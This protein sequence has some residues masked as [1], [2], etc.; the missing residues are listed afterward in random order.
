MA[1]GEGNH[2][3]GAGAVLLERRG[4][5][6]TIVLNRPDVRNAL[7]ADLEAGLID[8]L[9]HAGEPDVRAVVLSARGPVFCSGA[10]TKEL[11]GNDERHA[12]AL[13]VRAREL[14]ETVLMPLMRLEKPVIAAINGPAVGAGIGLALAADFRVCAESAAFTFAF[15]RVALAPDLGT[16]WTLPRIVGHRAARDLLMFGRT[17]AAQDALD[18][19]L[20]DRVVADADLAEASRELAQDLA[21]GPTLAL[22]LTKMLLRRAHDLDLE[23]FL[24]HEVLVQSVLVRSDDHQEGV[25]ALRARRA[26]EFRGH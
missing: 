4:S 20:A 25:T 1:M 10:N 2:G 21:Q 24:E 23:Q 7:T 8:A 5:V 6:L 18:I 17:V 14:P 12:S 16:C 26:P 22:G 15:G 3:G 13:R 11:A 9:G 19:G